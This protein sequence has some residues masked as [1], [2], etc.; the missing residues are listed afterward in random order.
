MSVSDY[1]KRPGAMTR[2]ELSA[3]LGISEGRLSQLR[4]KPWPPELAMKAEAET[5]GAL[6]AS[7]LSPI[8]A[9][10]RGLAA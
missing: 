5:R 9:Q 6:S 1:F 8:V 10:A 7:E 3:A 4:D 2:A